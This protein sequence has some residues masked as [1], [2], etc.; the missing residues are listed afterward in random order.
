MATRVDKAPP[1]RP[2]PPV[3][4]PCGSDATV[5]P[6]DDEPG[7]WWCGC[8]ACGVGLASWPTMNMGPGTAREAAIAAWNACHRQ[9]IEE[10]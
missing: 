3:R 4:C 10:N 9:R 1:V 8:L 7:E 2:T 5:R 6:G